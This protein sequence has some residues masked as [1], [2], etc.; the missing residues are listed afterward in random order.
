MSK[1]V[2]KIVNELAK[3]IYGDHVFV[4]AVDYTTTGGGQY[5]DVYENA[6]QEHPRLSIIHNNGYE[7]M[8]ELLRSMKK[9]EKKD[10]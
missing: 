8:I 10:A 4:D 9:L 5:I 7:L 3:E 6:Q 1:K 2:L